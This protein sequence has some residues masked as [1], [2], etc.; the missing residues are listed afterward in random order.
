MSQVA[1][2]FYSF[3]FRERLERR[4]EERGGGVWNAHCLINLSQVF[5]GLCGL[6]SSLDKYAEREEVHRKGHD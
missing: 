3:N 4:V 6:Q 5:K 2:V 1:C